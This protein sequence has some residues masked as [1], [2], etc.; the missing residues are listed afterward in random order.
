MIDYIVAAALFVASAL[1]VA[2]ASRRANRKSE[3]PPG[4]VRFRTAP[5]FPR[6]FDTDV[7]R[8]GDPAWVIFEEAQRRGGPVSGTYDADGNI[9]IDPPRV[10]R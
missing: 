1:V 4:A 3:L 7:V 6:P 9:H 2:V 5:G 10:G 8:P